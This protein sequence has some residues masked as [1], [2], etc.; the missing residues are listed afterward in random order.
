MINFKFLE[1]SLTQKPMELIKLY[2]AN[3][4]G[5]DFWGDKIIDVK[6]K[7]KNIFDKI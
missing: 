2:E 6:R 5:I 1:I 7:C 4:K 3:D